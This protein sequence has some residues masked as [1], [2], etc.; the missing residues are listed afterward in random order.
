MTVARFSNFTDIPTA[1]LSFDE[2]INRL[3]TRADQVRPWTPAV[4]ILETDNE[5]IFRADAPDVNLGHIKVEVENETLTLKGDRSIENGDRVQGYYQME[6]SYGSFARSFV[7][8]QTVDT[9]SAHANYAHGVLT[10]TLAKKPVA[11]ARAIRVNVEPALA[12][13]ASAR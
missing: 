13:Q 9:D 5:L 6:R 3:M 7:L 2:S 1:I 8:P 12:A 10:V 11:K 4:D